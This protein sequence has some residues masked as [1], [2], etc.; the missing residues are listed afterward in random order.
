M[1]VKA[2]NL[3]ETDDDIV[4][5]AE[6]GEYEP[7]DITIDFIDLKHLKDDLVSPE[8]PEVNVNVN[9]ELDNEKPL[10]PEEPTIPDLPEKSKIGEFVNTRTQWSEDDKLSKNNDQ[11]SLG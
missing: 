5:P 4:I 6:I 1:M 9:K 7:P 8:I 2:P 3:I 11:S 10:G